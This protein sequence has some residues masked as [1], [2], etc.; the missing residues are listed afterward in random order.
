MKLLKFRAANHAGTILLTDLPLSQLEQIGGRMVPVGSMLFAENLVQFS[1]HF[2]VMTARPVN[3]A[4]AGALVET[5]EI[6][7]GQRQEPVDDGI[8]FNLNQQTV[9]GDAAG[10][11]AELVVQV[12]EIDDLP[13]LSVWILAS[14]KTAE[15]QPALSEQLPVS[16]QQDA[17]FPDGSLDGGGIV[18][19]RTDGLGVAAGHPQQ[20]SQSADIDIDQKYTAGERLRPKDSG[21][22]RRDGRGEGMDFEMFAV[23]RNFFEGLFPSIKH[24]PADFGM[25]YTETFK[26]I[27]DRGP[28]Q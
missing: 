20:P 17:V 9:A 2:F 28:A 23:R 1:G 18:T 21:S 7:F 22:G 24:D 15:D 11:R 16:S 5:V 13:Q 8:L 27:L 6:F 10:K 12:V 14:Y 4:A 19:L 3:S 26:D 25:G